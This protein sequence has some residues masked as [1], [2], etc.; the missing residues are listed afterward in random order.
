M[1]G[2][3]ALEMRHNHSLTYA[4]GLEIWKRSTP[5]TCNKLVHDSKWYGRGHLVRDCVRLV[6]NLYECGQA[7]Y[8]FRTLYCTSSI[9][10]ASFLEAHSTVEMRVDLF[11]VFY[12]MDGRSL[13]TYDMI[14]PLLGGTFERDLCH[15]TNNRWQSIPRAPV[16]LGLPYDRSR[17]PQGV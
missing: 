9:R 6:K 11:D 14:L 1:L 12:F 2:M 16:S 3:W 17:L 15:G 5:H 10:T 13:S 4:V 8:S 7:V